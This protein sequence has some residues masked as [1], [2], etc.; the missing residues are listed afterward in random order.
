MVCD[1]NQRTKFA[2][3]IRLPENAS[4]YL[5]VLHVGGSP[6]SVHFYKGSTF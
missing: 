1:N 5:K 4:G 6:V 2:F 3:Q